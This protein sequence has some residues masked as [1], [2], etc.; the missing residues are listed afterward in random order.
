MEKRKNNWK[1]VLARGIGFT[2][3]GAAVVGG[4]MK[5]HNL[6]LDMQEPRTN[7]PIQSN[8]EERILQLVPERINNTGGVNIK[9]PETTYLSRKNE[10]RTQS[11]ELNLS[12]YTEETSLVPLYN[13][14]SNNGHEYFHTQNP[15][16]I[17]RVQHFMSANFTYQEDGNNNYTKYPLETLVE[18]GGDCEDL[19]VFA[20]SA[21]SHM[22]RS[23]LFVYEPRHVCLGVELKEG[24]KPYVSYTISVNEQYIKTSAKL[25]QE[26]PEI[27]YKEANRIV[28]QDNSIPKEKH[29]SATIEYEG[30]T[31]QLIESTAQQNFIPKT[32]VNPIRIDPYID[33]NQ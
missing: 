21:L 4:M 2:L 3:L 10:A 13:W 26:N 23:V 14:I 16:D 8:L 27:T 25:I 22:G 6:S 9:I 28:M 24:E 32:E 33:S 31:Y 1:K 29:E 17:E 19:T 12:R 20:A 7:I 15:S 5:M 18:R 30:I 11:S